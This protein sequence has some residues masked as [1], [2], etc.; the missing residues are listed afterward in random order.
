MK[1]KFNFKSGGMKENCGT[2]C[3]KAV[4][5]YYGRNDYKTSKISSKFNFWITDLGINAIKLGFEPI[6]YTY[7]HTIFEPQWLHLPQAKFLEKLNRNSQK[8]KI[9]KQ[10]RK[11]VADFIKL[12]GKFKREVITIKNLKSYLKRKKP[13]ILAVNSSVIHR[14][15]RFSSGHY[16]ILIG[17]RKND[18]IILNPG[19]KTFKEEVINQNLILYSLYQWGGWALIL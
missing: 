19:R 14:E 5:N 8:N 15:S 10:A 6:I 13:V 17:Y 12:G 18:F 2:K 3:L 7:S 11:S 16:I 1:L 9:L 4:L